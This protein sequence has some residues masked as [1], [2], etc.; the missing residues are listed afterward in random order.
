MMA[1]VKSSDNAR[2]F[3]ECFEELSPEAQVAITMI[4]KEIKLTLWCH[5]EHVQFSQA[6]GGELLVALIRG[7]YLGGDREGAK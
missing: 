5:N 6:M 3:Q 2:I 7:G 1:P 4:I